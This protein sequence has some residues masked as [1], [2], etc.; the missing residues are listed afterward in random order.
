MTQLVII[1]ICSKSLLLLLLLLLWLMN[2]T[3]RHRLLLPPP[4][5]L[6]T[7]FFFAL[8]LLPF[9]LEMGV[10]VRRFCVGFLP[11]STQIV[12][13]DRN[14]FLSSSQRLSLAQ[15]PESLAVHHHHP[16]SST[17]RGKFPSTTTTS[18]VVHLSSFCIRS[19][20][21]IYQDVSILQCSWDRIAR[22]WLWDR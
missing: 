10:T 5:N 3:R 14:F 7:L 4:Q 2:T 21:V 1:I 8:F 19:I 15:I 18:T 16:S 20:I 11:E 6:V 17:R 9:L 22:L 13:W 12:S